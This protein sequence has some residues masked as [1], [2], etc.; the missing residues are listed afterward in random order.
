MNFRL[1][2]DQPQLNQCLQ[3]L[4]NKETGE[5]FYMLLKE[6]FNIVS[7]QYKDLS[8]QKLERAPRRNFL[9]FSK[10]SESFDAKQV[11]INESDEDRTNHSKITLL[12]LGKHGKLNGLKHH[13]LKRQNPA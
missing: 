6:L 7:R 2:A 1:V 9:L 8:F 11:I 10:T 3:T 13:A 4:I 5:V 12:I